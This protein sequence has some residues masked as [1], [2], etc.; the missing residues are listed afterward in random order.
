[1]ESFQKVIINFNKGVGE[2]L[3][4]LAVI[5]VLIRLIMTMIGLQDRSEAKLAFRDAILFVA[6][7]GMA[8]AFTQ[9]ML[10]VPSYVNSSFSVGGESFEE[11]I[12]ESFK[13]KSLKFLFWDITGET[14]ISLRTFVLASIK[15]IR[16]WFVLGCLSVYALVSFTSTMLRMESIGKFYVFFIVFTG[17]YPILF[18]LID[19]LFLTGLKG[20]LE[21][22]SVSFAIGYSTIAN[23]LYALVPIGATKASLVLM[24]P[25]LSSAKNLIKTSSGS[26]RILSFASSAAKGISNYGEHSKALNK[27]RNNSSGYRESKSE[28][29]AEKYHEYRK[30]KK[31]LNQGIRAQ[32]KEYARRGLNTAGVGIKE[33]LQFR[34][35]W[36]QFEKPRTMKGN[37]KSVIGVGKTTIKAV[38]AGSSFVKDKFKNMN[39]FGNRILESEKRNASNNTSQGKR[40]SSFSKQSVKQSRKHGGETVKEENR[41][42]RSQ[43]IVNRRAKN[44]RSINRTFKNK[45]SIR[46]RK[47]KKGVNNVD[48]RVQ[49]KH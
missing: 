39:S 8:H 30:E 6:L 19:N 43:N 20:A 44:R 47:T 22:K 16:S 21:G 46:L 25:V 12:K 3:I 13:K 14:I 34:E 29:N 5:I 10:D 26:K 33:N 24:A 11:L 7:I 2:D 17:L 42:G 15:W 48:R 28:Q 32:K 41:Q 35:K 27:N 45:G 49:K 4:G 23:L 31:H 37:M 40:K 36:Q 1:M 38:G 18:S 9:I